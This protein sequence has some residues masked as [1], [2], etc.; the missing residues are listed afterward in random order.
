M[1]ILAL[2]IINIYF[3]VVQ[4]GHLH[5]MIDQVI[6]SKTQ[7]PVSSWDSSIGLHV[8]IPTLF[9]KIPRGEI[10]NTTGK[11]QFCPKILS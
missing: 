9:D 6:K 8:L 1:C 3:V 2:F 10:K 7:K 4:L 11:L 5:K